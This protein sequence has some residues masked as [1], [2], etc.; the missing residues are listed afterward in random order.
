MTDRDPARAP[1]EVACMV[2]AA[3]DRLRARIRVP[4]SKSLTNR[5]LVIAALADG[6]SRLSG[7][8]RSDDCDRLVDALRAMGAEFAWDAADPTVLRVRGVAGRPRAAARVDLGDGGTP[9]RFMLAVAAL[10]SGRTEIDGSAR[11]RERPIDEGV[12]LLRAIG[13]RAEFPR[14][15]RALPVVIEGP[16][17][18]ESLD[19]GGIEVGRT[20][21]SQFISALMLIAPW[22]ARGIQVRFTDE[23]TS[24]GYI[25]LS[26]AAL[27]AHGV[28]AAS[29]YGPVPIHRAAPGTGLRS[30]RIASQTVA[31]ADI[32]IEPDASS[33]VYPAALAAI[34]GGEVE[35]V[36]CT[37]RSLQPDSW[38]LDDLA[39]RGV[40]VEEVPSGAGPS[41]IVRSDGALRAHDADYAR[42]PDAAVM[43]MVLAAC[44]DRASRFTGLETL[45]VKE[46]DRIA[47]VAAGLRA[48]GGRVET[49]DDWVLVHP[50][51]ERLTPATIEASADHRIAMAFAVLGAARGGVTIDDPAVVAK[52]WPGFWST[53][54]LLAGQVCR[55]NGGQ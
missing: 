24:A 2:R 55:Q 52:S 39:L 40:T 6:E 44:A 5:H 54:D 11:M 13:A 35:L 19:G 21:S 38:F 3:G 48:L 22:T 36:G 14:V 9:T 53:L 33:A 4:G 17:E 18:G 32:A 10:A 20:A 31:G 45:R 29:A 23:P 1:R 26:L 12:D 7:A 25:A 49:G 42:A 51:P 46:S 41:V 34:M 30:I 8:L 16:R 47:T 50:L 43:A 37:R 15:P 27:G 28:D